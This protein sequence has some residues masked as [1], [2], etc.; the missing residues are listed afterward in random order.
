MKGHAKRYGVVA[1]ALSTVALALAA[2]GSSSSSSG[3]NESGL[4]RVAFGYTNVAALAA[5]KVGDSAGIFKKHGIKLTYPTS[6]A[7]GAGQIAQIL[8]GQL[9]F[10]AAGATATVSS[11]AQ[12]VPIQAVSAYSADY[13]SGGQSAYSLI[14]SPK[15][16]VASFKDLEGETVGGHDLNGIWDLSVKEAVAKDGG[17]ANAVKFVA[18]PFAN[19]VSALKQ[20]RVDAINTGQPFAS[21]LMRQGYKKIGDPLVTAL[22]S[23]HGYTGVVFAGKAYASKHPDV[24]KKWIAAVAE[25]A[26]YAK[27]HPDT[28][29]KT[30]SSTTGIPIDVINKTPIPNYTAKL[31]P[32]ILQAWTRLLVKYKVIKTAPP[33]TDVISP[34]TLQQFPVK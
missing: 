18:I 7:T 12:N 15:S 21:E 19:Q 11:A 9:T 4:T 29:R 25:S 33:I 27:A 1:G 23:P 22:G 6:A 16:S 31:D 28:T 17:N 34:I 26:T 10:A 2:C 20:G 3:G 5:I 24:I 32:S 14:V 13:D 30:I 8:N